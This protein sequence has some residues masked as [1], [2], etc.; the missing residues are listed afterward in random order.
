MLEARQIAAAEKGMRTGQGEKTAMECDQD[1]MEV[2]M[3]EEVLEATHELQSKTQ[4]WS[5]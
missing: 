2:D 3:V 4:D 5:L 1:M